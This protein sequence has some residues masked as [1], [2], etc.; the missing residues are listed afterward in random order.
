M[1]LVGCAVVPVVIC[2][3]RLGKAGAVAAQLVLAGT[4]IANFVVSSYLIE[5]AQGSAPGATAPWPRSSV[6]PDS[7]FQV[8][9][10]FFVYPGN[11]INDGANSV[12]IAYVI[13]PWMG[14]ACF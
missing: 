4:V 5:T 9:L 1:I 11:L 3:R 8:L 13:F 12:P 14:V 2:S 10:R 7:F 6:A